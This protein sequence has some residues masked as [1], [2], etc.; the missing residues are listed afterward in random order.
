[1]VPVWVLTA[2][3]VAASADLGTLSGVVRDPQ[4]STVANANVDV[5]CGKTTR[6]V[7]ATAAGMFSVP[8]LPVTSC[9]VSA[10][11]SG[12]GMTKSTIVLKAG[13]NPFAVLTLEVS[14]VREDVLVSATRGVAE[15]SFWVPEST[16]VTTREQLNQRPATL[17]AQALREEAGIEV[18]QTTSAQ[19]SPIIR[20][21][22][23]QSNVYL[24]DGVRLNTSTW[25]SGPSQYT[26]WIDSAAVD[27]LEVVRGP[28]S[29]QFGSDA[30]GG[31]LNVRSWQPPLV[32]GPTQ[33]HVSAD[34]S[35]ATADGAGSGSVSA[36]LQG[37]RAALRFGGNAR[38]VGA[39]RAGKG[40][41][42]HAAVTRFLG[43]P[44][45]TYG[46]ELRDTG[47]KQS[48]AFAAATVRLDLKSSFS[49]LY[50]RESLTGS[51][52]YDRIYGGDGVYR[53]GFNPQT[54]DFGYVKYQ[55]S[56]LAG[57]DSVSATVSVNRQRDGRF[58]QTRPTTV[59]DHQQR[60]PPCTGTTP[61]RR[62]ALPVATWS[63]SAANTTT[64]ALL[65]RAR[66]TTRSLVCQRRSGPMCQPVQRMARSECLPKT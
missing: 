33:F 53:S 50:L 21:F 57:F 52:R 34:G 43:L 18:Q 45:T 19:T 58:E 17:M 25:R 12:F 60:R 47:Y 10:R 48:G 30:L 5:T 27:R 9:T 54:L 41:D 13:E 24:I 55:R 40:I 14:D 62:A 8:G 63:P 38:D 49:G 11:A 15:S 56:G 61:K 36:S 7:V 37:K 16:S 32:S 66:R 20:G 44:N 31:T 42:S 26:A 64:R 28:G 59:D 2:M 23:G 51:S 35:M 46:P 29:V 3:M 22:T 39:M 65:R 1:M 6:H 4:G